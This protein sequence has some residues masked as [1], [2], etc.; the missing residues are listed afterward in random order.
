MKDIRKLCMDN[1]DVIFVRE[2][3]NGK[4]GSFSLR[5]LPEDLREKHIRRFVDENREPIRILE[6]F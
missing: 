5:E 6:G 3:L 2:T 1:L 4:W